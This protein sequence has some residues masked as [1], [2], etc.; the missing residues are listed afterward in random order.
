[1][2]VRYEN[3]SGGTVYAN[4]FDQNNGYANNAHER[5]YNMEMMNR[6]G[7]MNNARER[8]YG[9]SGMINND[10]KSNKMDRERGSRYCNYN[11]MGSWRLSNGLYEYERLYAWRI[12]RQSVSSCRIKKTK[13]QYNSERYD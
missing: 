3:I 12:F 11:M 10:N 13:A 9:I 5:S 2:E 6:N 4:S 1:M 8:G 7:Y